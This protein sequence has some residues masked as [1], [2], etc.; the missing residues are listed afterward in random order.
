MALLIRYIIYKSIFDI[1]KVGNCFLVPF[2]CDAFQ[3]SLRITKFTF[4]PSLQIIAANNA[5]FAFA[6]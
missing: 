4:L 6:L 3:K 2:I 5:P 1:K